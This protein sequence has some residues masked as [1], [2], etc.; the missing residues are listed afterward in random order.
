MGTDPGLTRRQILLATAAT[1]T[2][3]L[4]SEAAE[5]TN[6]TPPGKLFRIGVVSATIR[7]KPQPRNG[8]TWHFAQY[9]HPTADIDAYCKFVDPGSAKFFREY[10]RNPKFTFDQLPFPDTKITHYFD[11]DQQAASDFTKAFPGVQVAKS[12]EEMVEQVDAIWLG[13]AS[14]F[15]DDHFDLV[16]PGLRKG[17]PTFCDK[18]IGETVAGTRKILEFAKQH[19]VPIMSSS[20]FRHEWGAEAALRKRDSGEFGPIQYVI[21]SVQGGYSESGW[22]VYGQH[23]AWTVMT[24][25]GPGVEAVSMYARENVAHALVT[26]PDRMP[27]EIWFGRPNSSWEYCHTEVHFQKKKFEY[28]AGI[29][30]DFWYGHHY[31]MFRM[32][33]TF[34]EMV[35]TGKEPIPHQE[36]L[37]VTAIVHAAAKSL[38]EKSR[39][40]D[41]AEVMT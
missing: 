4:T 19:N 3:V 17:L 7:G 2:S 31:E 16:A 38:K 28:T 27:A 30:G 9:L 8:H 10:A 36:I 20:L 29:E 1:A 41:L 32:A 33:A 5:S 18:P 37:E 34:R 13:D 39:L 12:V 25:L 24:L 23:P 14:G 35:R 15:G 40:V 22:M 6:N 21:A 11:A 26:Y